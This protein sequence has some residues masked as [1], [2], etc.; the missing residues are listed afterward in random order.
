VLSLAYDAQVDGRELRI[1][2]LERIDLTPL[3]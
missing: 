2:D 3:R 1:E